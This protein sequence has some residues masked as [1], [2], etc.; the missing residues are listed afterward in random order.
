MN[1]SLQI[2]LGFILG[3]TGFSHIA[4]SPLLGISSLFL[5]GFLIL[6]GLDRF[7]RDKSA[8]EAAETDNHAKS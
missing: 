2:I 6:A 5:G 8:K 4:E 1:S 3:T 7:H